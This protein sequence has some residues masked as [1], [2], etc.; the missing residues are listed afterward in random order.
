MRRRTSASTACAARTPLTS[1]CVAGA[2]AFKQ[3]WVVECKKRRRPV[4]KLHVTALG[5]IVRDVGADRGVLLSEVGFQAGAV[6][7]AHKSNVT[8]TNLAELR[9]EAAEELLMLRLGESRLR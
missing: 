9:E 3:L 7:M 2:L 4:E 6:R 5:E 1:S 8:L